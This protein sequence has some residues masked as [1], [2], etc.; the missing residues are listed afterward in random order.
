MNKPIIVVGQVRTA[1]TSVTEMLQ[2][3][4]VYVGKSFDP[5]EGNQNETRKNGTFEDSEFASLSRDYINE[6]I[7]REEFLHRLEY[8]TQQRNE[9]HDLWGFKDAR[10][11]KVIEDYK[12]I[13][14]P[15]FV[16]THRPAHQCM[17]SMVRTFGWSKD[18][19]YDT[20][21]AVNYKL[22]E[23][24]EGEEVLNI[25]IEDLINQNAMSK[26]REYI[27]G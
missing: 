3:L 9:R 12:K 16:R 8:L 20:Y 13:I 6:K 2:E 5:L 25:H 27:Y 23:G 26:L 22:D 19:A 17:E 7:D 10:A 11:Y 18:K 4:G 14:K 24:L 1:S 21:N 15:R